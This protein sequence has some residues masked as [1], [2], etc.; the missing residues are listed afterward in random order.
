MRLM[1]W[2]CT[3]PLR[4]RSLV[5]SLL[6]RDRVEQELDEELRLHLEFEIEAGVERGLSRDDARQAAMRRLGGI[7]LRKEECRDTWRISFVDDVRQDVRY[8]LYASR[9]SPAFATVAIASLSLGI[10][11]N[12]AV[13]SLM[14]AL[15]IRPLPVAQPD[16]LALVSIDRTRYSFSYPLFRQLQDRNPAFS[17]TFAWWYRT[18]QL[19]D[20]SDMVLVP[21]VYGSGDY[22]RTARCNA[23]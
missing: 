2:L 20:G 22:F 17:G 6:R 12:T 3:I 19:R 5:R 7:E 14:D 15:L 16:R 4:L 21:A 13:F 23:C 18:V 9:K 10:G 1:E 8:A 11:A